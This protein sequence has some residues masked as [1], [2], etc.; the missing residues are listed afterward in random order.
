[1]PPLTPVRRV[2]VDRSCAFRRH[3]PP[4]HSPA[5]KH[6]R[7]RPLVVDDGEFQITVKRSSAYGLP[8]H[9]YS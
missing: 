6:Q 4:E 3:P 8:F 5:G 7:M 1:M 9:S 2:H